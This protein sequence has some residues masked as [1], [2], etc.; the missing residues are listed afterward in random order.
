MVSSAERLTAAIIYL[1]KSNTGSTLL[2]K[3]KCI[4][5]KHKPFLPTAGE[6]KI[7]MYDFTCVDEWV[8]SSCF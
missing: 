3:E 4:K 1:E 6:R 2:F 5:H 8:V 7:P